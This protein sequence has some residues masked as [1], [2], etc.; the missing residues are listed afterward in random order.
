MRLYFAEA[1]PLADCRAGNGFSSAPIESLV[2]RL[3]EA[4]KEAERAWLAPPPTARLITHTHR[5]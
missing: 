3:V 5:G 4:K 1:D 2:M